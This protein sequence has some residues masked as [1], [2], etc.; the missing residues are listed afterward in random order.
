MS[1]RDMHDN[2]TA[3]LDQLSDAQDC[4]LG[5]DPEGTMVHLNSAVWLAEDLRYLWPLDDDGDEDRDRWQEKPFGG[6]LDCWKVTDDDK[7]VIG[8]LYD[9][10]NRR[11]KDG[12][13]ICT[14]KIVSL[15]ADWLET[16][17]SLYWLGKSYHE[18]Y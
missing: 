5:M 10:P 11:F 12:S 14:S 2:L 18:Y 6:V 15:T 8:T 13:T 1:N 17:N 3:I 16:E 4:V 7:C 9:D